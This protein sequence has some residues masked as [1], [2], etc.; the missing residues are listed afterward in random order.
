[1][2]V[3]ERSVP[4]RDGVGTIGLSRLRSWRDS[5]VTAVLRDHVWFIALAVIYI[6]VSYAITKA[7][8]QEFSIWLYS[9][10][11]L[12]FYLNFAAAFLALRVARTIFKQRPERPLKVVWGDLM[13]DYRLPYR[14]LNGLP[15]FMLL[16][17][18]LSAYT[19]LKQLIPQMRPFDWDAAFAKID[20]V[21][22]GGVQ[23]WELLQPLLGTPAV[24][25]WVSEAYGPPW[26]WML[27]FMQ[28]WQIF[29]LDPRRMQFLITFLLCW[30]LLGNVLGTALASAGP[31]YYQN[32]AAG[33]DPFAPLMSYL[34]SVAETY[35]LSAFEAQQYLWESYQ[36]NYLGIGSG[37]SAM[38]SLHISMSVLFVLLTWG[39]HWV[40]RVVALAYLVTLL[41]GSVHLG[42]HYAIDGYASILGTTAIWWAVGRALRRDP[43][44]SADGAI[45]TG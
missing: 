36:N 10:F 37:I 30:V 31:V 12:L 26:F 17:F 34:A 41:L 5:P 27:L 39:Y 24:T 43:R 45:E 38:P 18:V 7:Y 35:K 28:F 44:Q 8:S 15:A 1:M 32:F 23:P 29:T 22:H 40:F 20:A 3:E 42:W 4:G 16:G 21:I 2:T 14:L 6:L 19:S 9:K 11:Q 25:S 33:P 13:G